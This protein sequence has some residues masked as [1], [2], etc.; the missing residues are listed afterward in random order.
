MYFGM[1]IDFAWSIAGCVTCS[2]G[3]LYQSNQYSPLCSELAEE[4][5]SSFELFTLHSYAVRQSFA[6][7]FV[8][9]SG[10]PVRTMLISLASK[11]V[12]KNKDRPR[13]ENVTEVYS[14]QDT[15]PDVLTAA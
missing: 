7:N 12:S 5:A 14:Q 3:A 2:I 4:A 6:K 8:P 9:F 11:R 15:I 13:E 10:L 1:S